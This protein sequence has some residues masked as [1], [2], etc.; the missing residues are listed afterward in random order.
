MSDTKE[1]FKI[2]RVT[3]GLGITIP[4]EGYSGI[5]PSVSLEAEISGGDA[6]S[7]KKVHKKLLEQANWLLIREAMQLA[8]LSKSVPDADSLADYIEEF[9]TNNPTYPK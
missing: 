3:V 5:R 1:E 4:M 2:K 6:R 7:V 9:F 8:S